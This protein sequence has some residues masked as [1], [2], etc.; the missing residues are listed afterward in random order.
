MQNPNFKS[1]LSTTIKLMVSILYK[2][3]L[4]EG[5]NNY[6]SKNFLFLHTKLYNQELDFP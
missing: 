2:I 1:E 6:C 5:L 4:Y 3:N